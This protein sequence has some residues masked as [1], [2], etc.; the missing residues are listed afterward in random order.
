MTAE[1]TLDVGVALRMLRTRAAD[2]D[3]AHERLQE[4]IAARDSTIRYALS[5]GA[6]VMDVVEATGLSRERVYQIKRG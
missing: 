1:V 5:Q 4:A 2:A 6:R 3:E